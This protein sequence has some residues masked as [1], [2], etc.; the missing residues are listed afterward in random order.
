MTEAFDTP[1]GAPEVLGTVIEQLPSLKWR[2]ELESRQRVIAHAGAAGKV[3]FVRL[4]PGDQVA[5]VLSPTDRTR[6]RIVRLLDPQ[7]RGRD[8]GIL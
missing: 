1:A 3:N 7:A 6:G 2:V 8:R 4:R 5:V